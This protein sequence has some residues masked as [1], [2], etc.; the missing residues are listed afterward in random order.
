MDKEQFEKS[1]RTG[2]FY[3]IDGRILYCVRYTWYAN[4]PGP[5]TARLECILPED[6]AAYVTCHYIGENKEPYRTIAEIEGIPFPETTDIHIMSD[7]SIEL[8]DKKKALQEWQE[9]LEEERYPTDRGST[10]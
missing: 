3:R 4:N 8:L 1:L 7:A 2:N 6:Y 9:R 10:L 5:D